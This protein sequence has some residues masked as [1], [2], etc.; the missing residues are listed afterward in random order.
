MTLNLF[1]LIGHRQKSEF[2]QVSTGNAIIDV[3]FYYLQEKRF[4]GNYSRLNVEFELKRMVGYYLPQVYIPCTMLVILSWISFWLNRRAA[5]VR[6][7]ICA[8]ALLLMVILLQNISYMVPKT[9]YIKA[10]DVYTGICMTFVF[11][12]LIGKSMNFGHNF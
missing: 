11:V 6:L 3:R 5:N 4:A 1:S 8:L 12:G 10:I 9:S 2:I 7:V